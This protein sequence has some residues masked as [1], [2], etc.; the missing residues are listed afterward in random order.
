MSLTFAAGGCGSGTLGVPLVVLLGGMIYKFPDSWAS[1][2]H[3][4]VETRLKAACHFVNDKYNVDGLCREF[5]SRV[6]Q[7]I[8]LE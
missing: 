8:D 7:L 4:L 2:K 3:K 6:Q 5:P 1:V